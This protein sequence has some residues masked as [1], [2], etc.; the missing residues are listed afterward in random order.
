[1]VCLKK[2]PEKRLF[3]AKTLDYTLKATNLVIELQLRNILE[4][5]FATVINAY[6][7]TK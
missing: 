4:T 3:L 2:I 7:F 1:M 6:C 5:T